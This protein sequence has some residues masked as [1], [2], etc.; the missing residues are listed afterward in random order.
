MIDIK[1]IDHWSRITEAARPGPWK[2]DTEELGDAVVWGQGDADDDL[3]A[4]VGRCVTRVVLDREEATTSE[5]IV[6]DMEEADAEFVAMA[7]SAM[8]QLIAEVR[9]LYATLHN[10]RQGLLDQTRDAIE[11]MVE[12]EETIR[13]DM[14]DT[15][16][17]LLKGNQKVNTND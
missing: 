16:A 17:R 8:P 4:N 1:T 9:D 6:F 5:Q 12:V 10:A 2:A 13:L 7:R 3:V 11:A 14:P 15:T